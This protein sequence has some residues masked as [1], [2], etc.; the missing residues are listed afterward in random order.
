M[1]SPQPPSPFSASSW[2]ARLSLS[3][4][5]VAGWLIWESYKLYLIS[6]HDRVALPGGRIALYL[7]A[8]VFAISLGGAGVRE[9][10]RDKKFR[11]P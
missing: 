3:F 6:H 1:D 11:G 4:F 8:A 7:I 2:L 5:I 9:R 10:H